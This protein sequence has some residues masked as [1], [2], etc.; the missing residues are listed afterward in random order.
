[1]A[2]EENEEKTTASDWAGLFARELGTTPPS[3]EEIDDLLAI[4]GLAAHAS[5]R[6]AAPLSTWLVGRAGV[7]PAAAKEAAARLAAMLDR[8]K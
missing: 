2:F 5:E 7:E 8:S 3:K 1:V 6:V 4:A